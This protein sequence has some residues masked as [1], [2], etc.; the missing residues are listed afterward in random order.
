MAVLSQLVPGAWRQALRKIL[1]AER[2][3]ITLILPGERQRR[4][5][6]LIGAIFSRARGLSLV[7]VV[8][9][10]GPKVLFAGR[11]PGIF[12]HKAVLA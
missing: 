8:S 9:A 10:A 12:G 4:N 5:V 7:A 6:C 11:N 2:F 3:L 1:I